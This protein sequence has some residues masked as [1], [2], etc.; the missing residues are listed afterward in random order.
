MAVYLIEHGKEST[1]ATKEMIDEIIQGSKA[2]K[3]DENRWF[4]DIALPQYEVN[5]TLGYLADLDNPG[6]KITR[7]HFSDWLQKRYSPQVTK[8][9]SSSLRNWL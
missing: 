8:W 6:C 3:V 5:D 4:L 2:I 7:L 1:L 9:L